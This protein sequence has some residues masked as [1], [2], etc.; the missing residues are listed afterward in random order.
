[1]FSMIS[2]NPKR[3]IGG[4]LLTVC[5]ACAQATGAAPPSS[6]NSDQKPSAVPS[7]DDMASEWLK[8]ADIAHMPSLHNFHE[9]AACG[10]EL[11]GVNYN[12]GG[13]LFDWPTGPR[14][15]R[16]ITLPLLH[17]E[18]NGAAPECMTCRWFPYQA[19]RRGTASGLEIE[20]TVRFVFEGPGILYQVQVT[21][22]SAQAQPLELTI[23]IPG[24][25][26]KTAS[27]TA[28]S[29]E[30]DDPKLGMSHAFQ[31]TTP[32]AGNPEQPHPKMAHAFTQAPDDLK[33]DC[34]P[35]HRQLEATTATGRVDHIAVRHGTQPNGQ[36][37]VG[38]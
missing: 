31:E 20:T 16:Y 5:F 8:V 14:W 18:V 29:Y 1:M 37:R 27:G 38:R 4:L 15:F 28:V 32:H 36:V 2:D 34:R 7:L 21:N 13:Q 24:A 10:P 19:V 22:T 33:A 11:L 23:N 6:V 3:L 12:P 25:E 30:S 17:L 35:G 9:M 26:N